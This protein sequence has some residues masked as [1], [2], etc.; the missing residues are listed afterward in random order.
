MKL[1]DWLTKEKLSVTDFARR[2]KKP[3]PTVARYVSGD[4]IPEAET[5]AEIAKETS[6]EVMPNDFY[7][8]A[9]SIA[10]D[11]ALPPSEPERTP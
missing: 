10:P 6:Y 1:K 7:N 3:Q 5:M 11:S 9:P 8:V 2:L 4:R